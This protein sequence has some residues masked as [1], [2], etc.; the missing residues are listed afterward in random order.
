VVET[1]PHDYRA[2]QLAWSAAACVG[3]GIVLDTVRDGVSPPVLI[4]AWA[5]L[6]LFSGTLLN[7]ACA[8]AS[9][10]PCHAIP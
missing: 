6:G 7:G 9:I 3:I 8:C 2:H 10:A 5:G 4:A 1:A